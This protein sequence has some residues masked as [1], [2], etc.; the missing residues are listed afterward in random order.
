[1]IMNKFFADLRILPRW[2]IIL[3]DLI[4]ILISVVSAYFL[5]FN[6]DL[7]VVEESNLEYAVMVYGI[8]AFIAILNSRSYSGIVRYTTLKD[9]FRIA[10][11]IALTTSMVVIVNLLVELNALHSPIPLSIVIITGLQSSVLLFAYRV[12]VK[13]LFNFYTSKVLRKRNVIVFGAGVGGSITKQIIDNDT[14]S[15]MRVMAYVEDDLNKIGKDL[16]GIKIYDAGNLELLIESNRIDDLII[17]IQDLSI[18]R[19]NEVV[20]ICLKHG[21]SVRTVP[22]AETWIKGELSVNQIRQVRIED[23]LGRKS[24]KLRD[25]NIINEIKSK[26]VCIT[27]AAGSIGSELVRQVITYEPSIIILL[28]QAESELYELEREIDLL[29]RG[30]TIETIVIDIT[31]E[32]RLER[33]FFEFRPDIVYHAAAYK[34]VPLMEKNPLEAINT[35]V[36]ATKALADLSLRF[37]I[38]KFVLISTDKAVNPTNVMG[39]SKRI[40]ELYVQSLN[41]AQTRNESLNQ[42]NFVTTRF[43]NVLGSN[44]SVIP[45]FKKQIE[46]GGPVTVTH[47]EVTRYFMTI[48]E[49]CQ[50]VL[51]AGAMGKGGEIFIFDMGESIKIIDLA[52]KMIRLSGLE[53]SKDIEII[54]T[55]LRDGEK[56]YEELL[57][58]LE[59]TLPTHHEKILIAKTNQKDF[60]V[61]NECIEK[62]RLNVMEGN[63]TELVSMMKKIVPDYRSH[64]S[65]FEALDY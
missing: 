21:I 50:L 14:N 48:T 39:C 6:F 24:I 58:D 7:T 55:G 25:N 13:Y 11:T 40:A 22:S 1:M 2:I 65:K 62:L 26:R 37:K 20:D 36:I 31:N 38:S 43:G 51:E 18:D 16:G 15:D 34:H 45:F 44:G 9:G 61:I 23:L 29:N 17:S 59:N 57:A 19:K 3:L 41:F 46:S 12:V 42:T 32:A 47:P 53:E 64:Y 27:G 56:L 54:Y 10:S 5:R 4:I 28:D 63:E 30:V 8:T 60:K 35:N 33:V 52:K 49:A